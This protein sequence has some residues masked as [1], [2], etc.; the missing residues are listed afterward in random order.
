ME[1]CKID[2]FKILCNKVT[3]MTKPKTLVQ[4]LSGHLFVGTICAHTDKLLRKTSNIYS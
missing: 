1:G 4:N 3:Y 2:V